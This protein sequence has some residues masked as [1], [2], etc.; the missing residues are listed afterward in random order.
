MAAQIEE[1]IVRPPKS[2]NFCH[3][4][5]VLGRIVLWYGYQLVKIAFKEAML[6]C[7]INS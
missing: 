3:E 7:K 1:N 6:Q 2:S 5:E 4:G